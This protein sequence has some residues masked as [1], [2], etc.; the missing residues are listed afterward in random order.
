MLQSLSHLWAVFP[1]IPCVPPSIQQGTN[2]QFLTGIIA[3]AIGGMKAN[4][5]DL[6][7]VMSTV[8]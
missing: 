7:K 3:H 5:N 4:S 8:V 2:Q 1:R 6:Y